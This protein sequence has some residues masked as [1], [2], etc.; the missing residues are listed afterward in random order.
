MKL[1]GIALKISTD[2]VVLNINVLKNFV[3]I[4]IDTAKAVGTLARVLSKDVTWEDV[5][6]SFRTIGDSVKNLGVEFVTDSAEIIRTAV[7]GFSNFGTEVTE[8]SETIIASV[9]QQAQTTSNFVVQHWDQMITGQTDFLGEYLTSLRTQADTEIATNDEVAA[10]AEETNDEIVTDTEETTEELKATWEDYYNN[11]SGATGYFLDNLS[12]MSKM[13]TA[14]ELATIQLED[15][16]K[17]DILKKRLDSGV[18]SQAEYDSKIA[19]LN[20]KKTAKENEVKKKAFKDNK[21]FEIANVVMAGANAIMGWWAAAAKL[22]PI[23]GPIFAGIMTGITSGMIVAQ[24]AM[25]SK[26][27]FIPAKKTG[28]MASGLT[29][30]NEAGG[31][32]VVLPDRS[33]VIP[34]DISRQI[35][36]S[37]GAQNIINVSFAGAKISNDMDLNKITNYVSRKL[38]RE[39]RT[40]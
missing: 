25:I 30:I 24:T 34:N 11:I 15:R 13:H 9:K 31:E 5:K 26:Q 36:G 27:K 2:F 40:A 29:R 17:R 33:V 12:E 14:N 39:L 37:S 38:A 22:G 8:Q 28:G 1:L 35:A 19:E 18:I 6:D 20:N 16:K 23:A 7:D 4:I 21:K 3:K 10:D 32:M